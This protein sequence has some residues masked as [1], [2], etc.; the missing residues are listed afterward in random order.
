M[1]SRLYGL[2]SNRTFLE[3]VF[4]A[5][6][7]GLSFFAVLTLKSFPFRD[8]WTRVWLSIFLFFE[9]GTDSSEVP[10]SPEKSTLRIMPLIV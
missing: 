8:G 2:G 9:T 10:L 3:A 6:Y 4:A 7:V 1:R 5:P